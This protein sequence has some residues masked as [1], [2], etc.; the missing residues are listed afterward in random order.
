[1]EQTTVGNRICSWLCCLFGFFTGTGS[2]FVQLLHTLSR[3]DPEGSVAL[4]CPGVSDWGVSQ[5]LFLCGLKLSNV[6]HLWNI[7]QPPLCV[8]LS[9]CVHVRV[10]TGVKIR[11]GY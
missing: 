7:S 5:K 9:L 4:Y 11:G 3:V 10:H 8:H 6:E 2:T 1:M